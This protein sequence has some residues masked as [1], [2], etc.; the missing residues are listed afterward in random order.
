MNCL[1]IGRTEADV[2]E[3]KAYGLSS[4]GAAPTALLWQG[5]YGF[6]GDVVTCHTLKHGAGYACSVETGP[7]VE[8]S[9]RD[10]PGLVIIGLSDLNP[11][12]EGSDLA[13]NA[14]ILRHS[15]GFK[16]PDSN[17]GVFALWYV[18]QQGYDAIY[19]VGIDLIW[20]RELLEVVRKIISKH[21]TPV[22][23]MSEESWLPCEVKE[24]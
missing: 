15:D 20:D 22:Y 2:A 6:D 21:D 5:Y 11:I 16:Y 17:T 3:C 24:P 12:R 9:A 8:D 14:I 10:N 1:L 13:E 7:R 19:T 4:H 23:K 18:L